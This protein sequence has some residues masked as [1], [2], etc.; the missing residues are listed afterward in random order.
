MNSHVY[1]NRTFSFSLWSSCCTGDAGQKQAP[2]EQAREQAAM[3]NSSAG[4]KTYPRIPSAVKLQIVAIVL[5]ASLLTVSW[6]AREVL[7]SLCTRSFTLRGCE[8]MQHS[9]N[10]IQVCRAEMAS[11]LGLA[12]KAG[13][14]EC[15]LSP[16]TAKKVACGHGIPAFFGMHAQFL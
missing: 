1:A 8:E 15:F 5:P 4:F 2:S 11:S 7:H 12:C 6:Y 13:I 3:V 9:H 10:T 14:S 16:K